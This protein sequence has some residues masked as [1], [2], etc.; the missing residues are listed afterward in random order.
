MSVMAKIGIV[1]VVCGVYVCVCVISR[2]INVYW[3]NNCMCA[4]SSRA[5]V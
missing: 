4:V 3:K 5:C 2:V 1:I